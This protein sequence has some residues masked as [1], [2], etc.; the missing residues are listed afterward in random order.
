MRVT[1][2]KLASVARNVPLEPRLTLTREIQPQAGSV[3]V[4][5][6][7]SEKT[8]YS[9]IESCSGR[10]QALK[11][12][13]LV[14]GALGWRN[15]LHGYEGRVPSSIAPGQRLALLNRGGV[16]GECLSFHPEV[17][18]PFELE[19]LGQALVYPHLGSRR[20]IPASVA[21]YGAPVPASLPSLP[22]IYVAGTCMNSGKTAAAAALIQHLRARGYRLA[23]VK[24]TGVASMQDTLAMRD[25]GALVAM[26]FTDAGAVA[27]APHLAPSLARALFARLAELGVDAV[28]AETGDG[29]MGEYG[30]H[31]IL[32]DAGLREMGAAFCF[33]GNDPVGTAGGVE[34]LARA[35]GIAVDVVSGPV[36]DNGVGRRF[37]EDRLGLAAANALRAPA[38]LAAVV[39]TRLRRA[40]AA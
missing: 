36:T 15:A 40:A 17:G 18:A 6:V 25:H 11:P 22:V 31:E 38:D 27:T 37:I 2:D 35:H 20:G 8:T 23:G 12:G 39:E 34:H 9:R 32:A 3:V 21:D 26:D 29:I 5:R 28:V 14:C 24:L 16:I 1:V 13:D 7:L 4:G 10:L 33:C 19:I 30:V